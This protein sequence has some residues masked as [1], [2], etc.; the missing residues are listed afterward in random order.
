M[1]DLWGTILIPAIQR[2][3]PRKSLNQG[4]CIQCGYTVDPGLDLSYLQIENGDLKYELDIHRKM[5]SR[6][7]QSLEK[8]YQ[9][10][11]AELER[12]NAELAG[13]T[14]SFRQETGWRKNSRKNIQATRGRE[15]GS[16]PAL[17]DPQHRPRAR[18]SLRMSL[19][20]RVKRLLRFNA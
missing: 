2:R 4:A 17:D 11:L 14:N 3:Y 19:S 7:M 20:E 9:D 12:R 16:S 6:E 18:L 1:L 15:D 5:A 8:E 13:L 10:I